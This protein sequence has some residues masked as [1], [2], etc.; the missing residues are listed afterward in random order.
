MLHITQVEEPPLHLLLGSDALQFVGEKL[1][2][3]QAEIMKWAPV[4]A[5]TDY[6]KN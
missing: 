6:P 2:A 3:L 1:G 4:S 5:G